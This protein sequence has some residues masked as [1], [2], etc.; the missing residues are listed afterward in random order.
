MTIATMAP[1]RNPRRFIPGYLLVVT[2]SVVAGALLGSWFW[3]L[4]AVVMVAVCTHYLL[5][6]P[7]ERETLFASSAA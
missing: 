5:V 4:P 6:Y 7:T 3:L 2:G 1:V